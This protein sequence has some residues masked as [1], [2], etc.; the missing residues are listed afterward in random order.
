VEVVSDELIVTDED[1][2]IFEYNPTNKESR[3]IQETLFHEKQTIIESCLF[4][5]DINPNSVKICRLRLWIELLKNAYYKAPDFAELETL[6]NIDVNIKCGNSL[7][8]RY[9]LD[10]D[11]KEALRRSKWNIKG[12]QIAVM[13]YRNAQNKNEKRAMEKLIAEIKSNFESEVASGDKRAIRLKNLKDELK[14]HATQTHMFELTKAEKA[15]WETKLKKL[16]AEMSKREAELEE[17]K[18]NKIYEN[19]FEWRFEFPEVLNDEGDFI[20]FDVVIGNPPY[21]ALSKIKEQANYFEIA[22]YQTYSKGSDIYCLFYEKGI[23]ILKQRGL[24]TYITSNSWLRTQY[25]ALLRKHLV[26]KTNPLLLLNIEDKQVFEEA[27]VESNI[28]TIEKATWN[29]QMQAV[30]LKEGF[31]HESPLQE[32]F[33]AHSMIIAELPESG[34]T[35]GSEMEVILKAKIENASKT[36]K[37][38][39]YPIN[40]GIK[41]GFNDAF[42]ISTEIKEKLIK[43]DPEC[44]NLIKPALR[45][46]DITK[47]SYNWKDIWIILIKQGWTNENKHNEDAKTYFS[48]TY[49]SVYKFL[50]TTG[51]NIKGKGKG[52]FERDDQGDYWWELRPCVYYEEFDKEKIVWGELSDQQKYAY[53]SSGLFANNTIFF[54]TGKNLKY[55]LSVLNSKVAKWYFNEIST[56]SGMGT[57]R[58][59]KYKI[60]QLPIK[61]ISEKQQIPFVNLVNQILAAKKQDPAADTSAL[62]KEIDQLVYQLY[63]LTEEEIRIVEG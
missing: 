32:Y 9:P 50:K 38:F 25:G 20:G 45:G 18:S 58:W 62:E 3:R 10:A 8:S 33:S 46:K 37:E 59:L 39:D 22:G 35:I 63:G 24:L 26:E 11:I 43:E 19:A 47:Y 40:Y 41:T 36:I 31:S 56:S 7:I 55:L 17:I 15:A 16:T 53:D 27:T 52:L 30:S 28:I 61:D 14:T 42:F 48:R 57:N 60:E 29:K 4:G 5:V 21:F 49:P 13:A 44:K 2:K 1:G 51:E 54:I 34:W 6:P 23:Q 12:Y